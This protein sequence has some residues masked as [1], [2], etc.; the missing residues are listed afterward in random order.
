MSTQH[1]QYVLLFLV[2]AVI[3]D[4]FQSLWS[5]TLLLKP[6]FLR[7]LV[8]SQHPHTLATLASQKNA[9]FCEN[10]KN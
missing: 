5:Y 1:A 10:I 6:P 9:R 8:D 3:S 4:Q 2:L 7:T